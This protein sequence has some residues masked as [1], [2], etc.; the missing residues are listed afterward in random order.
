MEAAGLLTGRDD[1]GKVEIKT[2]KMSL[3]EV[4][5]AHALI[6]AL[7][8]PEQELVM[9]LIRAENLVHGFEGLSMSHPEDQRTLMGMFTTVEVIMQQLIYVTCQHNNIAQERYEELIRISDKLAKMV[10]DAA[11]AQ[12]KAGATSTEQ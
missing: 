4:P 9:A 5:E 2:H 12:V 11:R 1:D 6:T 8:K 3:E 10:D 7:S